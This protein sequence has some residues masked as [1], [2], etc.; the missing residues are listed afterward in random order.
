MMFHKILVAIDLNAHSDR[1]FDYGLH[2][3]KNDGAALMVLNTVEMPLEDDLMPMSGAGLGADLVLTEEFQQ[4]YHKNLQNEVKRV[5]AK[6][7]HYVDRGQEMGVPVEFDA[8]VGDPGRRICQVAKMW[9][10]D[11]VLVGRRGRRG[12]RE[13]LLGSVS[14]YV[15]H[16]S[17]CS[18]MVVQGADREEIEN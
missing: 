13:L 12:L 4:T 6:L 5:R 8:R 10:A 16:R 7:Q 9:D 17:P 3:A 18:V 2:L 15:L 11:L 1:V 14:N